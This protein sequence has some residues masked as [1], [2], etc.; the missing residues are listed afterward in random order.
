LKSLQGYTNNGMSIPLDYQ[1][2]DYPGIYAQEQSAAHGLYHDCTAI[3]QWQDD[4]QGWVQRT[5]PSGDCYDDVWVYPT[6]ASDR[7]D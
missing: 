2:K 7:G 3:A 6:K 4:Q 5:G 1:V